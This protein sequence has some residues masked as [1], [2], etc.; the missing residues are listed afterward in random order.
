MELVLV[1]II[2]ITLG[3]QL[4]QVINEIINSRRKRTARSIPDYELRVYKEKTK[5][6]EEAR[7]ECQRFLNAHLVR[8]MLLLRAV[9]LVGKG[10]YA[11]VSIDDVYN[12]LV[13]LYQRPFDLDIENINMLVCTQ[14]GYY[15]NHYRYQ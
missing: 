12:E 8:E 11:D 14:Q 13:G 4:W 3:M 10:R 9:E 6:M 5:E 15:R 1:I 7:D 2:S